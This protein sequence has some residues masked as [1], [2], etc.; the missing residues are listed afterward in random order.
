MKGIGVAMALEHAVVVL[1]ATHSCDGS[2]LPPENLGFDF[3]SVL[4]P[5]LLGC[6]WR[7]V[8]GYRGPPYVRKDL[9][10]DPLTAEL[11][12]CRCD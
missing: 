9:I 1:D 5:D 3:I 4:I 11:V 2:F 12:T 8:I 7:I 6:G 10:E